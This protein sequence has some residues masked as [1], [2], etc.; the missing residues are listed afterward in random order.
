MKKY[1]DMGIITLT[2]RRLQDRRELDLDDWDKTTHNA[3][4]QSA[5]QVCVV[6]TPAIESGLYLHPVRCCNNK[7]L[8]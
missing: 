3:K 1:F 8:S 4:K 5:F 7:P 6:F 2:V